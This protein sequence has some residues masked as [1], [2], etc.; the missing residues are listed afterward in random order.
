MDAAIAATADLKALPFRSYRIEQEAAEQ[1][2][3]FVHARDV[4]LV[5]LK[6]YIN[7][8]PAPTG[9][10]IDEAEVA[11]NRERAKFEA[12]TLVAS[13]EKTATW[14]IDELVANT[15]GQA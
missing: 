8:N 12:R 6:E 5:L 1:T 14:K 10:K 3:Q 7:D 4:G 13:E 11:E 2:A 15:T 9:R